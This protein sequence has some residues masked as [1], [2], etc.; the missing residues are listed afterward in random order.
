M[1]VWWR[2]GALMACACNKRLWRCCCRSAVDDD[3]DD[4][5]F[6][7]DT[8]KHPTYYFEAICVVGFWAAS[9]AV[10]VARDV[11]GVSRCCAVVFRLS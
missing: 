8:P 4:D 11:E 1:E 10:T 9:F 6:T 5:H 3:D 7:P 2:D